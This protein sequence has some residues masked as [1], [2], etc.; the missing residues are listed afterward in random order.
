MDLIEATNYY[1]VEQ[2]DLIEWFGNSKIV[3]KKGN[4]L[5]VYHGTNKQFDHLNKVGSSG[6]NHS[7]RFGNGIYFTQDISVADTYG[8]YVLKGY[9][10]IL[11]P[12]FVNSD[13]E[14]RSITEDIINNMAEG[15][16]YKYD[17]FSNMDKNDVLSI[18]GYDGVV[19]IFNHIM[20]EIIIFDKDQFKQI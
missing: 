11:N 6:K 17:K 8:T 5:M 20:Q 10:K 19:Y 9:L 2:N 13:K 12:L 7:D 15:N 3:D 1:L 14:Y 18:A 4:P 16:R